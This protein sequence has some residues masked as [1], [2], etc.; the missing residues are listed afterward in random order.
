MLKAKIAKP[1]MRLADPATN[2]K[3]V[4][5]KILSMFTKLKKVVYLKKS[6]SSFK[7]LIM[8]IM[9]KNPIKPLLIPTALP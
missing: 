6:R 8:F 5:S 4:D 9:N 7:F 2:V 1:D 3:D